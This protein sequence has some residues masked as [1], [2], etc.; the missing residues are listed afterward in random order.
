MYKSK[1]L[2]SNKLEEG[3][4]EQ[5]ELY[6]SSL[7]H[8]FQRHIIKHWDSYLWDVVR[9]ISPLVGKIFIVSMAKHTPDEYKKA[10]DKFMEESKFLSFLIKEWFIDFDKNKAPVGID[11]SSKDLLLPGEYWSKFV[12]MMTDF[13]KG[14]WSEDDR[15]CFAFFFTYLPKELTWNIQW[16]Q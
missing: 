14:T 2:L 1:D 6:F 9:G 11:L 8:T 4:A 13:K 3:I 7:Q 12:S 16:N 5:V 15:S 10:L